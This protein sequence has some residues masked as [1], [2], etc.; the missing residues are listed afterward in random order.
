MITG[1]YLIAGKL[2]RIDSQYEAVHK[3][4][5]SYSAEGEPDIV[6]EI[7]QEDINSE[8]NKN[9]EIKP[10]QSFEEDYLETL[11][12]YRKI[13][14]KMLEYDTVLMHGSA[15]AV[16]GKGYIF[17]AKSG[18]GK[19]THTRLW[20]E[21]FGK[22]AFMVNDDKPLLKIKEEQALV[23]GTPWNGKHHLST[24]TKIPLKAVC[25]LERGTEN[26]IKQIS[27][28]EALPRILEQ[29]YRPSG[30][31]SLIKILDLIDILSKTVK[32][33]HL[34]CNMEPEAANVAYKAMTD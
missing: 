4:C 15:I 2:I 29:C 11:A 33:Y 5:K 34:Q 17:I 13:S 8:K 6:V 12:V 28:L 10:N 7:L 26:I 16:D 14:D 3:L 30:K 9:L 19:S 20:R 32:F 18:T 22:R 1:I 24:N 23:Y 27:L 25:I 21:L 31:D